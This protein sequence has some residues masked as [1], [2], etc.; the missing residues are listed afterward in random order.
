MFGGETNPWWGLVISIGWWRSNSGVIWGFCMND[1]IISSCVLIF[2][3]FHFEWPHQNQSFDFIFFNVCCFFFSISSFIL[4]TCLI[5]PRTTPSSPTNARTLAIIVINCK[6]FWSR[7][8][9]SF[10]FSHSLSRR[11]KYYLHGKKSDWRTYLHLGRLNHIIAS[12]TAWFD[13]SEKLP[14][15]VRG[16]Y[17]FRQICCRFIIPNGN[18]FY[19]FFS[20]VVC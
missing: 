16:T 17:N 9:C 11:L 10:F 20:L 8:L 13:Q 18:H 6:H 7:R 5:C 4:V 15:D 19:F 2:R 3:Q 14:I 1:H 12:L